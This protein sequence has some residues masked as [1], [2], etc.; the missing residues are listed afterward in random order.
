MTTKAAQRAASDAEYLAG[1]GRRR[2]TDFHYWWEQAFGDSFRE[3]N[4]GQAPD[5]CCARW[6]FSRR[7]A[8][9]AHF[10]ANRIAVGPASRWRD[11]PH[12]FI[13]FLVEYL[14]KVFDEVSNSSRISPFDE[15]LEFQFCHSSCSCQEFSATSISGVTKKVHCL[16][17]PVGPSTRAGTHVPAPC[18]AQRTRSRTGAPTL[19]FTCRTQSTHTASRTKSIKAVC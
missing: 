17:Q 13:E 15:F 9:L 11:R 1:I 6:R 2:T 3:R 7:S 10:Q 5:Q 12:L 4:P 14:D 18:F 19:C 16:T 8:I